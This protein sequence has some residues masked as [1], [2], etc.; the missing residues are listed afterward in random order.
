MARAVHLRH[1]R[2]YVNWGASACACSASG[3]IDN[4]IRTDHRGYRHRGLARRRVLWQ[5]DRAVACLTGWPYHDGEHL[6]DPV[7][8]STVCILPT[9]SCGDTHVVSA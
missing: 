7:Q 9:F 3:A 5:A 8:A 6:D 1:R 2:T 4:R